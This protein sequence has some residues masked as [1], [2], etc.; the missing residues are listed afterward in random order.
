MIV[1]QGVLLFSFGRAVRVHVPSSVNA[2]CGAFCFLAES[3]CNFVA[4]VFVHLPKQ[5]PPLPVP[6]HLENCCVTP[7]QALTGAN[8]A[9]RGFILRA[10]LLYIA[11]C[12]RFQLCRFESTWLVCVC[13]V[14][15]FLRTSEI[16][17]FQLPRMC[18]EEEKKK[19]CVALSPTT[20]YV[21]VCVCACENAYPLCDVR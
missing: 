14:F 7:R 6:L 19:G 21:S 12:T 5:P 3:P 18:E 15:C 16:L 20:F 2:P 13:F 8:R 11:T 1:T 17:F 10:T 4:T 9:R